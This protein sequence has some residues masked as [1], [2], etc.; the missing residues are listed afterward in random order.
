MTETTV[1]TRR[2]FHAVGANRVAKQRY[3]PGASK[4]SH[5]FDMAVT[6]SPPTLRLREMEILRSSENG[7]TGLFKRVAADIQDEVWR[8]IIASL[9]QRVTH[10][11]RR[12]EEGTANR[13]E[14]Q[15]NASG[16][17]KRRKHS[18]ETTRGNTA[19]GAV[20]AAGILARRA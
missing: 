16:R 8:N 19:E 7:C 15:R 9:T 17:G 13:A 3:A 6:S 2:A 12:R 4:H 18:P 20:A 14:K 1:D 5:L 11:D 10:E